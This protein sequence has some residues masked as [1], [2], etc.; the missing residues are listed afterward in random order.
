MSIY[1]G[2]LIELLSIDRKF[3]KSFLHIR[4][5]FNNEIKLLWEID[6]D[7]ADLLESK[8]IFGEN[9]KYRLSLHS[10]WDPSKNQYSSFITKT[11]RDQSEKINFTCSE[12][13]H[14]GLHSIKNINDLKTIVDLPYLT[15]IGTDKVVKR[16]NTKSFYAMYGWVAVALISIV[17]TVLIGYISHSCINKT[18]ICEKTPVKAESI[19]KAVNV[20]IKDEEIQKLDDSIDL[21]S[22]NKGIQKSDKPKNMQITIQP[23][24]P[25]IKL[26][27]VV[28]YSIPKGSVALTFDDGP[29]KYSPKI[30]NL[31]K[32]YKT[33]GTFF[34][35][36]QNVKKYPSYVKYAFSNGFSVGNHSLHH[37]DYTK[38]SSKQQESD[39]IQTNKLIQGITHQKVVLFRPPYGAKNKATINLMEKHSYKMV[40][41]NKDTEDWKNRNSNEIIKYVKNNTES[42]CIILLHES[43]ASLEALPKIIEYLHSKNLKIVSL[44]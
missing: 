9:Y 35:I 30:V 2:K 26:N 27:N 24:L 14:L 22:N 32:K 21:K 42:G 10:S 15:S 28:N 23:N 6:N 38:L 13:Y 33:G 39:M 37:S 19:S 7:T 1:H 8:L 31:L 18:F 3:D 17:S 41:W 29:S 16:V 5:V 11:Y 34:Y 20:K 44:N 12:E 4:L 40:L 25:S 43:K 36:G